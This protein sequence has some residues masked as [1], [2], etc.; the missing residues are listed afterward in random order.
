[1]DRNFTHLYIIGNGFDIFTGHNTRYSDFR[2][3]LERKNIIVFEALTSIYGSDGEWWND[4]ESQLGKLDIAAY[5]SN[6]PR[7]EQSVS[8]ILDKIKSQ[9]ENGKKGDGIPIFDQDSS[10]ARRL[11]GLLDILQYCF[12]KWVQD[13]QICSGNLKFTHIIKESFFINFNYTDTLEFYYGIPEEQVLHIHGRAKKH[14]NLVFGHDTP[15]LWRD[16]INDDEK[17][18]INALLRYEKNPYVYIYRYNLLDKIKNI[19]HIH[20]LGFSFS[21][22]DIPY[23]EWIAQH[24]RRNCDWEV[25]W[26]S[27]EDKERINNFLYEAPWLRG[28]LRL[29]QMEEIDEP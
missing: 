18:V 26:Y 5:I 29:F 15:A 17:K 7:K 4:F 21:D 11:E 2:K 14:E 28:R 16:P 23:L 22:V 27:A 10:C 25:S 8:Q 13:E 6:H 24:T 20:V 12:E 1:M 19:E 9:S 3:W